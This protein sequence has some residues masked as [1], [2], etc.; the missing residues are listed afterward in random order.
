MLHVSVHMSSVAPSFET[1]ATQPPLGAGDVAAPVVAVVV[2]TELVV[3][4]VVA[5]VDA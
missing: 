2:A 5:V 3:A 4:V 1:T